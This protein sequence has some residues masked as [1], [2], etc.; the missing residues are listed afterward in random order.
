MYMCDKAEVGQSSGPPQTTWP[1]RIF[2]FILSWGQLV[3]KLDSQHVWDIDSGL[4]KSS[5]LHQWAR[6]P[7][8]LPSSLLVFKQLIA[9]T[10]DITNQWRTALW[11]KIHGFERSQQLPI[12]KQAYL[13]IESWC[14]H[15][16]LRWETGVCGWWGW[17]TERRQVSLF[18][19]GKHVSYI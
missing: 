2:F 14:V 18:L 9:I 5:I 15:S 3:F 13:L 1:I 12:I 17:E 19:S 10:W 7:S 16:P 6:L 4:V 11:N 8:A